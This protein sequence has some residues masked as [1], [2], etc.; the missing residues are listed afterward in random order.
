MLRLG[1]CIEEYCALVVETGN[2]TGLEGI[3][4]DVLGAAMSLPLGWLKD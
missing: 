2:C 1:L 3:K 4:S